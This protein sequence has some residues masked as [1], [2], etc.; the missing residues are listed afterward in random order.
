M[1]VSRHWCYTAFEE[2]K[3]NDVFR[4]QIEGI[5]TCP[6]TGRVHYQGYI[7]LKK[8]MRMAGVKKITC[9]SIHLE[10]RKGT[11]EQARD[12]CKKENNFTEYGVWISGQGHRS[13]LERIA[14]ELVSGE[15]LLSQVMEEEPVLFCKYRNGLKDLASAGAKK[16]TKL[17][18]EL[19]VVVISGPTGCGKTRAAIAETSN[20]YKIQGYDLQWFDGYEQETEL[21]IDEYDNDVHITK[22]LGLLDR[23][24]I[25]LPIKG[26][27]S[28]ANWNTVYITTNLKKDEL[29]CHAKVAHR[30]AL[31]RRITE[32][33]DL[34][35]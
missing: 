19:K 12:Y 9:D 10:I 6:T 23:Y 13:D 3:N 14:N 29:H 24:Q 8:P 1:S 33:R 7:E 21:L 32:W 16:R 18:R 4:Y 31:F 15:V 20:A 28:Y 30:E 5:E 2:I 35:V 25:R 17:D 27:F 34:W 26:G 22:M 11:R